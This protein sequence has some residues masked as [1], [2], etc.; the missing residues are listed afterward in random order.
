MEKLGER[1]CYIISHALKSQGYNFGNAY[2]YIVEDL[3]CEEAKEIRDFMKYICD[4]YMPVTEHTMEEMFQIYK[5]K[6]DKD[7]DD[8]IDKLIYGDPDEEEDAFN[9]ELNG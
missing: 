5:E 6:D 4:H 2:L 7:Y 9:R 8:E 1:N 3:Y